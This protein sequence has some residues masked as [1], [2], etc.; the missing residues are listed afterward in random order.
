MKKY[1]VPC[2]RWP[3]KTVANNPAIP[4]CA[5]LVSQPGMKS[6]PLPLE[7]SLTSLVLWPIEN[8]RRDIAPVLGLGLKMAGDS[9]LLQPCAITSRNLIMLQERGHWERG[10]A[11][12]WWEVRYAQ[13]SQLCQ[14]RGLWV[15]RSQLGSY[16]S[17]EMTPS[18]PRGTEM[19]PA[20]PCP[21][22]GSG[23]NTRSSFLWCLSHWVLQWFLRQQRSQKHAHGGW[24]KLHMKFGGL[25]R[26]FPNFKV[27]T[28]YLRSLLKL[29]F[30]SSGAGPEF[31]VSKK[32]PAGYG[33]IC[34][35]H[36]E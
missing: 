5:C 16:C 24:D 11:E 8:G 7:F 13:L 9:T 23:A 32:F 21:K 35:P 30:S 1:L 25:R 33:L 19:S 31:C 10:P 34:G 27:L 18:I 14:P 22:W 36:F 17:V 12:T 6:F 15:K 4:V 3:A 20:Q 28:N 29:W 26:P 2:G